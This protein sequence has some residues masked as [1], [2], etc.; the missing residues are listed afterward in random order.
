VHNTLK[1]L[2]IWQK[3]WQKIYQTFKKLATEIDKTDQKIA[4]KK[5]SIYPREAAGIPGKPF[6]VA[7]G[8]GLESKA[9]CTGLVWKG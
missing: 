8:T 6:F 9:A 7:D 1:R 3:H 2:T 5:L 4:Q